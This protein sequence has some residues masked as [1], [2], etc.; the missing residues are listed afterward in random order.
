MFTLECPKCN[1]HFEYEKEIVCKRALGLHLSQMHGMQTERARKQWEQRHP[2]EVFH[3]GNERAIDDK[4]KMA[5]AESLTKARA[6]RW[7]KVKHSAVTLKNLGPEPMPKGTVE[8]RRWHKRR[9]V[10]LN[11][12]KV[13]AIRIRY[14]AK[15]R[16][17]NPKLTPA[18]TEHREV[19]QKSSWWKVD[20]SDEKRTPIKL[21]E[22]P[23][24][25]ARFMAIIASETSPKPVNQ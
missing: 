13:K 19:L 23:C 2:G 18:E 20:Y 16:G 5:V 17:G 3:G 22:C 10:L 12:G 6:A 1:K 11:P 8:N 9:W 25:G 4:P 15:K 14:Y 21:S 7:A 24:C